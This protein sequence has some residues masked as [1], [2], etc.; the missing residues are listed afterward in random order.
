MSP[1]QGRA[2][3]DSAKGGSNAQGLLTLARVGNDAYR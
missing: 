2:N 1:F 3:R